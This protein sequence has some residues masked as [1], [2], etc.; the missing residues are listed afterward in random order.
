MGQ[1]VKDHLR[2]ALSLMLKPLVRL[3]IAQGVTHAEFA[4]TAMRAASSDRN[5]T[6]ATTLAKVAETIERKEAG[7]LVTDFTSN[8]SV[9]QRMLSTL[10][11][12]LPE[13]V[14]I[15]ASSS[16]DT[17]DMI[18]LINHGQIFRYILKP[19]EPK[20]L[21]YEINAA[22]IKHLDL[23]QSP[24]LAKRHQVVDMTREDKPEETLNNFLTRMRQLR[25]TTAD[26]TDSST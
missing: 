11:Q 13:L 21:M 10:K 12:L 14:T 6:L 16:R 1:E 2:R 3:L 24:D 25:A 18:S 4:E 22:S 19:I 5:V 26:P 17:T 7:V 15:V 9:L 23:A 20:K 8:S